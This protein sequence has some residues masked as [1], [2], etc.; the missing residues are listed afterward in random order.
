VIDLALY[1]GLFTLLGPHVVD[2]DQLGVVQE[3]RGSRIPHVA[4]R[5][6]YRTIDGQ[7]LAVAG[8]TQSTFE[9]ICRVLGL[10]EL[11]GDERFRD[12]RSRVENGDALD[13]AIQAA[14]G[15][16]TLAEALER[17]GQ[18]EAPVGPAYDVAGIF[19]DPHY[20]ARGN[21][22]A[23]ADA[24]L[25]TVRMQ[26]PVPRL[27]GTPGRIDHAGPRK[28]EHNLEVYGRLLGLTPADLDALAAQGAI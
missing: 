25:G 6:T 21:I 16:L 24:E 14:L 13:D 20:R 23:V 17:F 3:R 18:A 9:R 5:N 27:A 28:G 2:Y 22:E 4:P 1:E 15:R 11:L 12:N 19:A 8:A 7:W 10:D 26:A